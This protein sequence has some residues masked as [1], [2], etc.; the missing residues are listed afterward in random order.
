MPRFGSTTEAGPIGEGFGDW[1]AL[2]MSSRDAQ[3]TATVPWAC[4]MDWDATFY[5]TS[6]P[7]CLRRTDTSLTYADRNGSVHH[8]GQGDRRGGQEA[9]R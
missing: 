4:I 2:I 7:H 9:L 6:V 3:D 5:S 8:D 1:W